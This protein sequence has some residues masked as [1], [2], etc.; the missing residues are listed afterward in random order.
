MGT[1]TAFLWAEAGK[2]VRHLCGSGIGGGT[3][4]GLCRKLVGME[5][6]YQITRLMPGSWAV[7]PVSASTDIFS[8]V[9]MQPPL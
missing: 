6:F 3:L 1:G 7:R 9:Q 2:E 8:P 4:G 5:R